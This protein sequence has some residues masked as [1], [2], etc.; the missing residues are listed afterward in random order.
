MT[1]YALKTM[2][3]RLEKIDGLTMSGRVSLKRPPN[4]TYAIFMEKTLNTFDNSVAS[5]VNRDLL[6]DRLFQNLQ[7]SE[8]IDLSMQQLLDLTSFMEDEETW[9]KIQD[10]INYRELLELVFSNNNTRSFLKD[11]KDYT[12]FEAFDDDMTKQ[13]TDFYYKIRGE[14]I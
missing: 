10:R 6:E 14:N 4:E 11:V 8:Y 12:V 2:Q 5:N 9:Q 7:S 3:S 1:S 13:L